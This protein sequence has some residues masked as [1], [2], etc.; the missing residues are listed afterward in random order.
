MET[1]T[2]ENGHNRWLLRF[3]QLVCPLHFYLPFLCL[4]SVSV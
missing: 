3:K 2:C 1:S 4:F